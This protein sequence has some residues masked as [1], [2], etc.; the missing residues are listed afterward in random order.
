H[1]RWVAMIKAS[2]KEFGWL[3]ASST[4]PPAAGPGGR[5]TRMRPQY[6]C[7]PTR[8][9]ALSKRYM[10]GSCGGT[11]WPK[12]TACGN[13]GS[14]RAAPGPAQNKEAAPAERLHAARG[15]DQN[16]IFWRRTRVR[17]FL[18]PEALY[19]KIL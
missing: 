19:L 5:S 4:G 11:T 10:A 16:T 18:L 7:S 1:G 9:Y 13:G 12:I 8:T 14:G 2:R 6:R 17:Y 3:A 15:P